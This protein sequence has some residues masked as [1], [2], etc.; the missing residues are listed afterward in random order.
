MKNYFTQRKC[1]FSCIVILLLA[2][3]CKKDSSS[4]DD[5]NE[6][7]YAVTFK[8]SDFESS[9]NPLGINLS[10]S[11]SIQKLA[12]T[13]ATQTEIGY[14]YY[15]SFNQST[16]NPDIALH[17]GYSITY[18]SGQ[19]PN[20]YAT[21]FA[22]DSYEAGQA[23]SIRSAVDV[24]VKVSLEDALS[25][26]GIGFDISS[27]GTGPKDFELS[28]S[29][30]G[31]SSF[32]MI[33]A[34]NQFSNTNTSQAKNT[35]SYNIDTLQLDFTEDF[36]LKFHLLAGQRGTAS[37]YNESTGIM[38]LDNIHFLGTADVGSGSTLYN[39]FQYYIF[40]AMNGELVANGEE[41]FTNQTVEI[42]ASLPLGTYYTSFVSN[43]S[44]SNL[45]FPSTY[46]HYEDYYFSNYFSNFSAVLFGQSD[47]ITVNQNITQNIILNRLYSQIKFEF[48]DSE[49]LSIVERIVISQNHEPFFYAPFNLAM[50]NPILDQTEID[51]SPDFSLSK[52]FLFNQ[53]MGLLSSTKPISYT[54]DV[55]SA[56]GILRTFT[57]SSSIKNNVQLVFRGELLSDVSQ[58]ANF[59]VEIN[60]DWDEEI[61][62]DF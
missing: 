15:W 16:L 2:V 59:S 61:I 14:L 56:T 6:N 53:F 58:E 43:Q 39:T 23:I 27:S 42:N 28:Y 20:E 52:E 30:D 31:G 9:I 5:L 24:I 44:N 60:E 1:I 8:I 7:L 18:N 37:A 33:S 36:Y 51:I 19:V 40:D 34:V 32:K 26:S 22:Y 50:T 13:T 17:S 48:T 62:V 21:G 41:D 57:V 49:D 45:I 54:V 11:G 29:N 10:S 4:P 35:F 12:A 38:R 55:Y 46:T 47:T 25:L 3:A